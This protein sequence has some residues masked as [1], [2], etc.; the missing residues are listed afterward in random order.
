MTKGLLAMPTKREAQCEAQTRR[1]LSMTI[2][3][4]TAMAEG[5]LAM[6]TKRE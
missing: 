5:V 2:F 1:L 6:P 4:N 3:K